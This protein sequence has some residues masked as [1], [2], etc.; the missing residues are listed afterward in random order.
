MGELFPTIQMVQRPG[1][2]ELGWGHPGPDLLPIDEIGRAAAA[3][4]GRAG[5]EAL[6]YGADQGPAALLGWLCE[7]IGQTEGRAPSPSEIAITAGNSDALQQICSMWTQPGDIV[8]VESPTYHLA[9]RILRDHPLELLPVPA[10]ADGLR[11][12]ALAETLAGLRRTGRRARLLYTVPTFHNPTGT[13]LSAERRAGL[14]AL[15]AEERLL[16]VED[17][18][19]RELTYDGPAPASLWSM[20][21]PGV[22]ARMGSFAKSLAPGLRLGWLTAGPDLIRRLVGSGLRDSGGGVNHF[23]AMI[24]AEFCRAGLFDAN[25]ARLRVV[26]RTRRDTLLASL[27]E[28]LPASCRVLAPAG[29]YFVWVTLPDRVDAAAVLP[30]AEAAGVS[31]LPGARFH[32]DGRGTHSLRL[33]FSLYDE[34]TLAEAAWRLSGTICDAICCT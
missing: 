7:R 33:A 25:V 5:A 29:G 24:V 30:A 23:A 27:D 12:D 17:D 34:A 4:L 18:V 14:V 2:I 3:M 16:I 6:T 32:T 22:V 21:P 9:V 20:A 11:I 13:S 1:I 15:A 19:Y 8:L 28:H 26:Y 10:D 31:Y